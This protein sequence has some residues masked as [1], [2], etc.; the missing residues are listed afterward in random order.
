M[1]N[2]NVVFDILYSLCFK[3]IKNYDILKLLRMRDMELYKGKYFEVIFVDW[4]QEFV[5]QCIVSGH[6]EH[7]SDMT[8]EE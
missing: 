1:S 7:L 8:S 4:C 2:F 3:N 5:G 6:K